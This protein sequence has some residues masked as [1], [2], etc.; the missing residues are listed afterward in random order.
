[1]AFVIFGGPGIL[2]VYFPLA[3]TRWRVPQ[4]LSALQWCGV[5]L[6][7]A[8]TPVLLESVIRFVRD[9]RGT[10]APMVPTDA[11][12]VNGLYRYVRNPMY[13][14]VL[15]AVLGQAM[16]FKNSGLLI[17]LAILF[18]GF[19]LF[20]TAYEEPTLRKKYGASYETFCNTV[21]RWLPRLRTRSK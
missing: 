12:V 3:I 17:Y 21:P 4:P 18:C 20:I 19:H 2:A 8:A 6:I 9:G 5:A 14:A 15:T 13:V 16:F 10:L 11:L 1:M 7:V